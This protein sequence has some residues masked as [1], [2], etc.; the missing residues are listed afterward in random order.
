MN[1]ISTLIFIVILIVILAD[2]IRAEKLHMGSLR[3]LAQAT[4]A[5]SGWICVAFLFG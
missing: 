4:A 1:L 5:Y 3:I 2:L